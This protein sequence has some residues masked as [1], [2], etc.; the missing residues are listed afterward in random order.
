MKLTYADITRNLIEQL[1]SVS[2]WLAKWG[3]WEENRNVV[4]EKLRRME[5][6]VG[7]LVKISQNIVDEANKQYE[8]RDGEIR[9]IHLAIGAIYDNERK[10]TKDIDELAAQ[11]VFLKQ[12][13]ELGQKE[14]NETLERI[15]RNQASLT[16]RKAKLE[17]LQKW[18]WVPGYGQYLTTRSL[19]DD[20]IQATNRLAHSLAELQ[21][22]V[23][24]NRSLLGDIPQTEAKL[25]SLQAT[26]ENEKTKLEAFR[27]EL[28]D[29][30]GRL[31]QAL[32]FFGDIAKFWGQV[33]VLTQDE[34]GFSIESVQQRM[35]LLESR[36]QLPSFAGD[37]YSR[38]LTRLNSGE[39]VLTL[40]LRDGILRLA[41]VLDQRKNGEHLIAEPSNHGSNGQE[42]FEFVVPVSS[43]H[44]IFRVD[45]D[46]CVDDIFE[47]HTLTRDPRYYRSQSFERVIVAGHRILVTNWGGHPLV[48]FNREGEFI[49]FH[50]LIGK[51]FNF[52][53]VTDG[54]LA[55]LCPGRILFSDLEG[56]SRGSVWYNRSPD[57]PAAFTMGGPVSNCAVAVENQLIF[58][59]T[60]KKQLLRIDLTQR[61]DLS[62]EWAVFRDLSQLR[63]DPECIACANGSYFVSAGEDLFTFEADARSELKRLA[64]FSGGVVRGL[65]GTQ[66]GDLF[67]LTGNSLCELDARSGNVRRTVAVHDQ[68]R[69]ANGL[70]ILSK[71][72]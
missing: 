53:P 5:K 63:T 64:S 70:S 39:H 18:F 23:R 42:H 15:A 45:W 6:D 38:A 65:T 24:V 44:R 11:L 56:R 33:R 59:F 20:D 29:S 25:K 12:K 9:Q 67:V 30:L 68:F 4:R 2:D 52:V 72:E 26:H 49:N 40:T 7:H 17:E 34:A 3:P 47:Q 8:I 41:E 19:V 21:Q 54:R 46:G 31:K 28:N 69:Q 55:F 71:T 43:G 62:F 1:V 50:P 27:K 14:I 60:G 66:S 37:S 10:L 61:S 22:K 13:R 51:G 36:Q 57:N 35:A 48:T 16:D 58:S 32:V